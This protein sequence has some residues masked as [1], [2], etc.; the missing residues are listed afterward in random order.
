MSII[1]KRPGA[2][3]RS[4]V[5]FP[6]A[7]SER[8]GPAPADKAELR[9]WLKLNHVDDLVAFAEGRSV[10]WLDV[11]SAKRELAAMEEKR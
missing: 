11:E 7:W 9:A 2:D 4:I 3:G 1:E 6:E 5:S 8:H 10:P